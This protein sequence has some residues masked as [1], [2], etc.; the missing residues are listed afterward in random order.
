MQ[1]HDSHVKLFRRIANRLAIVAVCA[2][3]TKIVRGEKSCVLEITPYGY[4]K[5]NNARICLKCLHEKIWLEKYI[6]PTRR[7]RS[8]NSRIKLYK[9]KARYKRAF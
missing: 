3:A 1:D 9:N 4:R 6:L 7:M 5:K 2:R 8:P